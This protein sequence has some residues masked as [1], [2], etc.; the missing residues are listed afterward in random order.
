MPDEQ[1]APTS[2]IKPIKKVDFGFDQARHLLWRAGFGGTSEQVLTLVGWGPAKSVD[3]LLDPKG[4]KSF[5]SPQP[6]EF[7]STIYEE[8]TQEEAIRI[9][10]ARRAQDEDTLAALRRKRQERARRDRAQIRD[11]Q[12]WWLRRMIESPRPLEEKMTLFWHSHFATSYRT[13]ENSYHMYMQNVLVRTH[14]LGNFGELLFAIIRDPAMLRYL[15]NH[16]NVRGRPNENFAREIM[17]LFS[18]GE[19]H[20]S[21]RDIKEGARALTGYTFDGNEFA[22]IP[23]RHDPGVKSIL[24]KKGRMDGDDFVRMILGQRVC[25]EFIASKL[26]RFFV[27]EIPTGR[28]LAVKNARHVVTRMA[29]TMRGARYAIKPVLRELLLSEHFYDPQILLGRIKSPAELVVGTIRSLGTP[30]RDLST[31]LHAMDLMGQN[32]LLPPS[33]K[34]WDGERSWINTS[35]LYVRANLGHYLVTGQAPAG[36]EPLADIEPYDPMPLLANLRFGA[37]DDPSTVAGRLLQLALG[38]GVS[39]ERQWLVKDFFEHRG[40]VSP[41]SITQALSLIT[42]MPE[43]QLC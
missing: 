13:I 34:G 15:D 29:S 32:L 3:H 11:L 18:L 2:S 22:F 36:M 26:Y 17:E 23:A 42:A 20:Y 39:N 14:A 19:G 24:G 40:G 7:D 4:T 12:R 27:G 1:P 21:E 25:S 9:Q 28:S 30:P 43:Y 33:V 10:Q 37:D 6:D 5:A 41:Q 8:A 35:T 38:A 31:L 16:L